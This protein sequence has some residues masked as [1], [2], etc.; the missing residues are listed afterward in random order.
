MPFIVVDFRVTSTYFL[1]RCGTGHEQNQIR[2][3]VMQTAT[4]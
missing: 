3:H 1:P 4:R 2:L